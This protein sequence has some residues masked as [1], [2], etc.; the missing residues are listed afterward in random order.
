[1]F[2]ILWGLNWL[3][4]GKKSEVFNLGTG[5]GFSG[6]AVVDHSKDVTNKAVLIIEGARRAGDCTQLVSGS[7]KAESE[8]DWTPERSNLKAM[9]GDA[10]RWHQTGH[11][12]K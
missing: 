6:R 1:M 3:N 2:A 12:S 4:D 9:I 10:W 7:S 8:L 5:A 11:Y